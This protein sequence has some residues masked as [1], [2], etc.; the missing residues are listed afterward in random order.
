ML[1]NMDFYEFIEIMKNIPKLDQIDELCKSNLNFYYLENLS[2]H[3]YFKLLT[4]E[5]K[6]NLFATACAH[7]SID[8]AFLLYKNDIDINC[9][10]ELMLNFMVIIGSNSE[11]IIFRWIWEKKQIIF[12][13]DEIK[14]C[15]INI[16]KSGNFEFTD[17]F[18]STFDTID[19]DDD[20][21][22][23]KITD[24]VLENLKTKE[25]YIIAIYICNKYLKNKNYLTTLE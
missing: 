24:E 22:K 8:I 7:D 13:K 3:G 6:Y 12:N 9:V 10:K 19:W 4:S 11:Y 14:Y 17:W 25:D 15:L 20:N 21:L 2:L 16:L 18:C 5:Q 23:I 1:L